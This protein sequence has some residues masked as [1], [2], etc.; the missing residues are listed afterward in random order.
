MGKKSSLLDEYRFPGFRPSAKIEGK[1]GDPKAR[2][3]R[4]ERTQKKQYAG[5][6]VQHTEVI[7]T[8]KNDTYGICPAG[9]PVFICEWRFGEYIA[10]SVEK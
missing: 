8:R 5:V 4:L 10:G 6:V 7:T 9:M 3:I 1:F 2:V